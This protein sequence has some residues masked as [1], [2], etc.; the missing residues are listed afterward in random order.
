MYGGENQQAGDPR[1]SFSKFNIVDNYYKPGPATQPG[2]ISYRIANPS[3]RND[4]TDFG[5][6]YVAGNVVEGNAK[7]TADNWNGGIQPQGG[8][9]NLQYVKMEK[10][11]SAMPINQQTAKEAFDLVV[12]KAG[13]NLPKRD[14]IDTRIL[15]EAKEGNATFEGVTYKQN[16]NVPDKSKKIGIID[17]PNDVG[18]WPQLSS[19]SAPKDSDK[20][21]MPDDWEKKNGLNPNNPEDRNKIASNGYTMLEK[22]LNSIK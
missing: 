4:I 21:G 20:D 7:V 5:K 1:F 10:P 3:M 19:V 6:W 12:E 15:K 13:A 18:G 2:E 14:I 8:E 9:S 16:K 17:T 22:Y 11:W